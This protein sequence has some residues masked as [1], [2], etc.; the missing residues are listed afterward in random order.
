MLTIRRAAD[1]G[2]TRTDWLDSRHTFSFGDYFDP[3]HHHYRALRVINDDRVA[4]G[5]GFGTHPHRDMEIL[6]C[7]LSGELAHR[8]SMGHGEVIRPG[9]WQKMT[10]GTGIRHSEFNPSATDPVHLL[11]I[12]IVPDTKGLTPGYEQKAFPADQKRGR[13]RVVASPDGRDG[14]IR[15][16]QDVVL[17]ATVLQPGEA[18]GYDL[19]PGRGAWLHVAT[20]AVTVNGQ[21]LSAGDAAAIEG[22][23]RVEVVGTEDGEVLLF[24]LA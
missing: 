4:P 16:N 19:A 22:E 12:W 14:S 17:S 6:T 10:A 5:A 7:V 20:G 15:V 24:D 3:A 1:R 18:V 11:Q 23:P 21:P 8:D 13:W 9:E 2:V